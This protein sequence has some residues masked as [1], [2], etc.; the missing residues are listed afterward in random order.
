M[1]DKLATVILPVYNDE[2][3]I[4]DML[5]S[6]ANQTY[7]N[8]EL[9]IIDDGSTD[10][11][12]DLIK[13]WIK[14]RS[15]NLSVKLHVNSE[16]QGL[17][18]NINRGVTEARG[19]YILLADHD[20][21]WHTDKITKQVNYLQANQDVICCFSDRRLIDND[22]KVIFDSEYRLTNFNRNYAS[23]QDFC[24]RQT[25][26]SS[27]VMCFVNERNI[28]E[29]VFPIPSEIIEHDYYIALMFSIYKKIGYIHET[30]IDY[31]IHKS[32]LSRNY[33]QLTSETAKEY[34]AAKKYFLKR[35]KKIVNEDKERLEK[36][37][38]KITKK[39]IQL[40]YK[41]DIKTRLS[42]ALPGTL[43]FYLKTIKKRIKKQ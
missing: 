40:N 23:F 20:D 28:V 1:N 27:N 22:G 12:V 3:Y 34:N 2:K 14:E 10:K 11:S 37:L 24:L 19:D 21:V 4:L 18:A 43:V 7:K 25:K 33:W 31:R 16:T 41:L 35:Y 13:E 42:N 6:V 39:E 8:I 5:D 15:G 26:F 30:L 9:L 32:N 38:A 29:K 17:T 36:I